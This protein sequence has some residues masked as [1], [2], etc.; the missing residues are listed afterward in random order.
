[1]PA[2]L[3]ARHRTYSEHCPSLVFEALPFLTQCDY[4]LAPRVQLPKPVQLSVDFPLLPD[5]GLGVRDSDRTHRRI[6]EL[7]Q[8][9][10]SFQLQGRCVQWSECGLTWLPS[11]QLSVLPSVRAILSGKRS[12]ICAHE[13]IPLCFVAEGKTKWRTT[14]EGRQ[15]CIR[16]EESDRSQCLKYV[17]IR[18]Q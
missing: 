1:M 13:T 15:L 18:G 4:P 14:T 9:V 5:G 12:C 16:F 3:L 7:G 10:G 11:A 8:C 2:V 17:L 6:V